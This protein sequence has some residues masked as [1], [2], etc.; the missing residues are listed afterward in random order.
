MSD[1][2]DKVKHGISKGVTTASVKSKEF[3]DVTKLKN[4]ISTLQNKKQDA[5]EELGNI[6]YTMFL[7][8]FIDEDIIKDKGNTIIKIDDQI[9]TLQI[10]IVQVQEK[11]RQSLGE[12]GPTGKCTCGS[13]LDEDTNFCSVCGR[14]VERISISVQPEKVSAS[15]NVCGQCKEE[16]ESGSKFCSKC[17]AKVL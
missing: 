3:L 5:I 2:F 9:K 10:E 15:K 4:Q 6:V 13:N 17:G 14:K 16:L 12:D 8:E 7:K 1:F 11:A